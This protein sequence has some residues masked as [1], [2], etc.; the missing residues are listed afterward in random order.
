MSDNKLYKSLAAI[1]ES[2]LEQKGLDDVFD[3]ITRHACSFF[4]ASASSIMLFDDNKEYLT[5]ARSF[6]LSEEYLR[7]VRVHK[8]Q[9]VAGKVCQTKKPRFIK[10]VLELF[11]DINDDFTVSWA[12][13]EGLISLV[14]A[15][16][17]LK[18]EAIGC[19]NI[20]YRNAQDTFQDETALDFF[21]RMAALSIDHSKLINQSQE[22]TRILTIL[23][24]VGLVLTSSFDINEIMAVFLPTAV[25][26]TTT[27]A[28]CL[29]LFDGK[30]N[31]VLCA[32]EY[33][34][35]TDIPHRYD[36]TD[37]L[38]T[39]LSREI[40]RT[41]KSVINAP[42]DV[43]LPAHPAVKKTRV[44]AGVPLIARERLIGILFM[45]ALTPRSFSKTEVDYL[46]ILC[47]QAAIALDNTRLY[48]K[49]NREAK[50]MS[51][52]YEVSRSFISTLDFD[53]LL[54]NILQQLRDTF[55][56]LNL[57]IMLVDEEKQEIYPRS[58]I[59][60]PEQI[61]HIRLKIGRDGI[62]GHVAYTKKMYYS[63]NVHEDPYYRPGVDE[64]K[65]EVCFP[66]MIGDHIIGVLDVESFD[67]NGFAQE[68]I[69]MLSGLSAQIAIALENSRL[70]EEA[71]KL[72]LTDPLT[73]LPNRRSFEIFLASET[74]RASRYRR[75]FSLLMIDYD[76]FKH[77]N[78]AYGHIA[79]DDILRTFSLLL[80]ETIRDVDFL[81]R[82]GGDEFIAVLPETDRTFALEVAERMRKKI[83]DQRIDPSITLSIG[84]ASF[85]SDSDSQE[86]LIQLADQ[87]CYEAKQLGGNCV[88]FASNT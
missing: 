45:D 18:N 72:S 24:E 34:K 50:E 12:E 62:T 7:V 58:Y 8:D 26:L 47:S 88:N 83:Q 60:Y 48:E 86:M 16:L 71:K 80:K 63:P 6:N 42:H 49:V 61:K 75:T 70:F 20:Y 30:N 54:K 5:I 69:T 46:Q 32:Y 53:K 76:N 29:V 43:P 23:E 40:I 37:R 10:N 11:K 44:V 4:N 14:C 33:K 13:K 41:N 84:I 87:A 77:Y 65:S 56:F 82:Y 25:L 3:A 67:I 2:L 39:E 15:P 27:D 38:D 17:L 9:E 79:G 1:T 28:S 22:K 78:D 64:A 51:I 85:P 66:L 81:G 74:R 68:D 52:L 31:H 35:G 59:N 73:S 57:A 21:T 55:G 36:T 19:L